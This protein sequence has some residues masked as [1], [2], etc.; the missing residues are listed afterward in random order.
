MNKKFI[1]IWSKVKHN[2]KRTKPIEFTKC[3]C[4]WCVFRYANTY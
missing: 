1:R 3:S 2:Y 4:P